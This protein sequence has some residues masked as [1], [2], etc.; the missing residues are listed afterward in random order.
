MFTFRY[1]TYIRSCVE[2]SEAFSQVWFIPL[3]RIRLIP[4]SSSARVAAASS[5]LARDRVLVFI[6][7]IITCFVLAGAEPR[8]LP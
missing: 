5:S 4:K 1:Y 3:E 7:A 6:S 2:F 8:G